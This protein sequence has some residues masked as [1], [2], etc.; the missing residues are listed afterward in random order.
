VFLPAEIYTAVSQMKNRK[1]PGGLILQNSEN[2]ITYIENRPKELEISYLT[3]I[4][5]KWDDNYISLTPF[6]SKKI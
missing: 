4:T 3:P 1:E 2:T 5:K 6:A